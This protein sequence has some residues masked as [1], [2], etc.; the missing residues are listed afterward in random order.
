M[1]LKKKWDPYCS[2]IREKDFETKI[3]MKL[4]TIWYDESENYVGFNFWPLF[5]TKNGILCFLAIW[6]IYKGRAKLTNETTH[7]LG[8]MDQTIVPGYFLTYFCNQKR[9]FAFSTHGFTKESWFLKVQMKPSKIK[10]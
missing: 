1:W 10:M 3:A 2:S 4:H 9:Y 5:V 7:N 8:L 6:I